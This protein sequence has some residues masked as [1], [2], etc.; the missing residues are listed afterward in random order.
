M[1]IAPWDNPGLEERTNGSGHDSLLVVAS[2]KIICKLDVNL[3]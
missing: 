2:S 3:A 1:R